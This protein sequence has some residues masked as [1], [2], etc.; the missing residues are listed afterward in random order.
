[1]HAML[2]QDLVQTQVANPDSAA[3]RDAPRQSIGA[4]TVLPAG[5]RPEQ[6]DSA[7]PD[8]RGNRL[9]RIFGQLRREPRTQRSYSDPLFERP[10]M[11]EDDYYRFRRS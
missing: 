6:S 8:I 4:Q 10:D 7:Q 5:T 2:E 3:Y 1:M 11:I 9:R